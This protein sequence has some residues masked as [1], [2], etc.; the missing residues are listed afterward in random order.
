MCAQGSECVNNWLESDVAPGPE[1]LLRSELPDVFTVLTLND[2]VTLP[3]QVFTA[4]CK[5]GVEV[6]CEPLV[7]WRF[8]LPL[9]PF[10]LVCPIKQRRPL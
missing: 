2:A 10:L 5:R 1:S 6:N 4:R 3:P 8:T 7:V 9:H